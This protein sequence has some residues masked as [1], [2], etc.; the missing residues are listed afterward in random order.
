MVHKVCIWENIVSPHQSFF[1]KALSEHPRV[2]LQVRYFEAFHDERKKLGWSDNSVLP[3]NE[4]YV[5]QDITQALRSMEDWEE[6]LHIIP[7]ISY[8]F[9]QKLL[10]HLIEKNVQWAHWSERSGIGLA[11]KLHYNVRLFTMLQP[12]V[13]K[14]AKRDYAQQINTFALGAFAQ[15]DLAKKDFMKWGVKKTK[16]EHLFYTIGHMKKPKTLPEGLRKYKGKKI[17]M[18]AGSLYDGK[19]IQQLLSAFAKLTH[20]QN[21]LL[22]LVG[23]D[24]SNGKYTDMSKNLGIH[25]QTIFTGVKSIN[26]IS[27]YIGSA[28]IFILPS[29]YDGW[30]AV[31]NEAAALGRAIIATDQCG[32][33]FHLIEHNKNGFR[34]KAGS[35]AALTKAMQHYVDHP[36]DIV[37]HGERSET[38]YRNGFTPEKNVVRFLSAVDKW[39]HKDID[40]ETQG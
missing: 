17:F 24:I 14:I 15:G 33:A 7:G 9:T 26:E 40:H 34:I 11:K 8:A 32:A 2:D 39:T 35:V 20:S 23:N 31:L 3:D 16:I 13:S 36:E 29:L 19:G 4:Q 18:Y 12:L 22:V 25:K 10:D 30:G 6:R 38:L 27:Q 21:W 5:P 28:D 1:F 37:R